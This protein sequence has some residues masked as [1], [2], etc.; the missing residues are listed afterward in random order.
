MLT[1]FIRPLSRSVALF[2][3]CKFK[4]HVGFRLLFNF[5]RPNAEQWSTSGGR[6]C[7]CMCLQIM[8]ISLRQFVLKRRMWV[9]NAHSKLSTEAGGKPSNLDHN[10]GY[11]NY[12]NLKVGEDGWNATSIAMKTPYY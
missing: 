6:L 2:Y 1:Y 3:F 7:V 8:F 10:N 5:R 11:C 12:D 4:F 9:W